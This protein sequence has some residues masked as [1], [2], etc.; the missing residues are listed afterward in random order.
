LCAGSSSLPFSDAEGGPDST[1]GPILGD[2]V[3]IDHL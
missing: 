2:L 3:G 1:V